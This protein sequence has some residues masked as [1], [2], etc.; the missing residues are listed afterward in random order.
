METI[1]GI[2]LRTVKYNDTQMIVDMFTESRG[3]MAFVAKTT[4]ARR[5][6]QSNAFWQA[7]SMVEFQAEV[8]PNSS[9][10]K[11]K[12]VRLFYNYQNVTLSPLKSTI[13]L[14]LAEFL[15]A[16]L[17][18][19]K[20]NMPLFTYI[21]S[22]LQWFDEARFPI[23]IANFHLVF[24]MHLSR[25][26]GIYPNFDEPTNVFDL[27]SGTYCHGIPN[28]HYYIMDH[29]ARILPLLFRMDYFSAHLFKLSSQQRRR[30]IEVLNLF[31]RLH[32]PTFPELKS[33]EVLHEV[34]S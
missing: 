7:L 13:V 25:F 33:I 14:F 27:M 29:E 8:K 16:A 17:R 26:L 10:A 2:V 11:P 5:T 30:I 9:L 1:R 15:A 32:I 3:R 18:E 12:E 20:Q 21:T 22:S 34:F 23:A 28:H 19:E 24:L 4:H 31:Y 6:G